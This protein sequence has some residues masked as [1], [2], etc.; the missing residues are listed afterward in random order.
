MPKLISHQET[1]YDFAFEFED[2][3]LPHESGEMISSPVIDASGIH[4]FKGVACVVATETSWPRFETVRVRHTVYVKHYP[5]V[6]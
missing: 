4:P 2:C 1:E 6:L 3:E 5:P